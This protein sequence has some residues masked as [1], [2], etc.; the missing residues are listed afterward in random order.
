MRRV[1][2]SIMGTVRPLRRA[3]VAEVHFGRV[4]H[5]DGED[6]AE[7]GARCQADPYCKA[8][9][10]NSLRMKIFNKGRFGILGDEGD[11]R[12]LR[13][14]QMVEYTQG[15]MDDLGARWTHMGH[16]AL[17]GWEIMDEYVEFSAL[18]RSVGLGDGVYRDSTFQ[19]YT[20]GQMARDVAAQAGFKVEVPLVMDTSPFIPRFFGNVSHRAALMMLAQMASCLLFEDRRGVLRFVDIVDEQGGLADHLDYERMYTPPKVGLD[21]FYNGVLLTEMQMTTE[22]GRVS[23]MY[24]EISGSENVMIPFDKPIFAGGHARVSHGFSLINPR[25]H[26]M[27]MTGTIIGNGRCDIE[28]HGH[29]A[30]FAGSEHFYPAPWFLAGQG[31]HPYVV[32]M[33]VFLRNMTNLEEVRQWFLR[34]KFAMLAKRVFCEADWRQNPAVSTGDRVNLQVDRARRTVAGHVVWQELDF[35]R[36]VLR[37]RTKVVA[38]L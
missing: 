22:H 14:R 34:R 12:Y 33:P 7:I 19:M 18:G 20:L 15:V 8:F 28:I 29:R 10:Q 17:D 21:T 37:G 2:I 36:G 31:Q 1:V 25:F 13:E 16:F 27:Y 24:M 38:Q 5:Y 26:V 32:N 9:P 6:I 3:R 35:V 4:M 11:A 30:D 23:H